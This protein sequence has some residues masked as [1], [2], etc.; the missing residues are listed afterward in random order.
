QPAGLMNP[1]D[2]Q[3]AEPPIWQTYRELIHQ[4]DDRATE[5]E[6][7]ERF[8]FYERARQAYAIIATSETAL[9]ANLIL[10]KGVVV[11]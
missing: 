3:A 9:Y 6:K 8:E 10:K 1:V 11:E 4:H 2:D 5:L 7:I